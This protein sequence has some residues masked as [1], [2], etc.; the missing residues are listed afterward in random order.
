MSQG[1]PDTILCPAAVDFDLEYM[2]IAYL[3]ILALLH[4]KPKVEECFQL[5]DNERLEIVGLGIS[6]YLHLGKI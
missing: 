3:E 2:Y 6:I 1:W 4:L 5:G